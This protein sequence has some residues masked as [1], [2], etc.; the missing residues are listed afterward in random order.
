MPE[1]TALGDPMASR[2]C[3][4]NL[5]CLA[6]PGLLGSGAPTGLWAL[7][8][9][10]ANGAAPARQANRALWGRLGRPLRSLRQTSTVQ[11]LA[12]QG[13]RGRPAFPAR[14]GCLASSGPKG[15]KENQGTLDSE[16]CRDPKVIRALAAFQDRK[17]L[18]WKGHRASPVPLVLLA[19]TSPK[20]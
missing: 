1:K 12:S 9:H 11:S 17:A 19:K 4:E 15:R 7:P 20:R 8:G 5:A 6:C 13:A 10:K 3:R 18:Q 2:V 16:A 14:T